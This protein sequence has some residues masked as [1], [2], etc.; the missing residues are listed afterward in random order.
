MRSVCVCLIVCVRMLFALLGRW[1]GEKEEDDGRSSCRAFA[2]RQLAAQS[3]RATIAK[4]AGTKGVSRC[5]AP[6]RRAG[7]AL[8]GDSLGRSLP[9]VSE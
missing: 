3:R 6:E 4:D 9:S 7:M 8:N 2:L 5:L 1:V